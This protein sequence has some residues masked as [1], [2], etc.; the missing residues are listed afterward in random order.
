MRWLLFWV[1][2]A[3]A[4]SLA[5]V[6]FP[7]QAQVGEHALVLNGLGLREVYFI[8][9]Y[10]GALYLPA[11]SQDPAAIIAQETPKRVVMH[12][13][14]E[15]SAEDIAGTLRESVALSPDAA[16]AQAQ[17]PTM[18]SW[19]EDMRAGDQVVLDYTPGL[20]TTVRVKGRAKG[21]VAGAAFMRAIWGI[22]LGPTPASAPLKKGMLGL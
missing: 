20:G 1:S 13:L 9:V 6:D 19:L 2:A 14:R 12:F 11:R 17:L 8:D 22:W 5:G 16:T 3:F 4:G 18:L 15:V 7:D 21:T 10:V